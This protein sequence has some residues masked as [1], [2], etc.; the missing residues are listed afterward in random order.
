MDGRAIPAF[1]TQALDNKP[2][3]VFGNGSQTRSVC[4]RMTWL[5]VFT[6]YS[7]RMKSSRVN[8]GNPDELTMLELAKEIIRI[9]KFK[10]QNHL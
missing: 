7:C 9:N 3:T 2:V 4:Y 1:I 5:K 6:V 8:I 10:E